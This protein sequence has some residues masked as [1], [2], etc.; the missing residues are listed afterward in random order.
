M[1]D[2]YSQGY[3]VTVRVRSSANFGLVTPIIIYRR[4][5]AD[6]RLLTDAGPQIVERYSHLPERTKIDHGNCRPCIWS[7]SPSGAATTRIS[8]PTWR[9][10]TSDTEMAHNATHYVISYNSVRAIRRFRQR[11]VTKPELFDHNGLITQQPHN[12]PRA[13]NGSNRVCSVT[14]DQD[15][16]PKFLTAERW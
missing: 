11:C 6:A 15:L 2:G 5:L 7:P 13:C 3:Q 14:Y 16:I 8:E 1:M 9:E 4:C 10:Q 12:E